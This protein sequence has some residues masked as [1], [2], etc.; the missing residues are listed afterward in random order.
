MNVADASVMSSTDLKYTQLGLHP[1]ESH[2]LV[3]QQVAGAPRV[4]E[5]GCATGY[6]SQELAARGSTVVAVEV[7]E[8]AAAIARARGVDVRVGSLDDVLERA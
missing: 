4:L 2:E 7:D 5:I 1:D 6:M 8:Q 3:L